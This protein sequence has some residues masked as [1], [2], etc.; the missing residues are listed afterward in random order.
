MLVEGE[1]ETLG[2]TV[3][4]VK[5]TTL[6][7]TVAETKAEAEEETV[8]ESLGRCEGRGMGRHAGRKLE[9]EETE[10][11]AHTLQFVEAKELT[12]PLAGSLV[13]PSA[14][15]PVHMVTYRQAEAGAEKLGDTWAI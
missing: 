2:D 13:L 1:A 10:T 8:G 4:D 14:E 5:A 3:V 15:A 12:H 9:E 6:V 11:L 7:E